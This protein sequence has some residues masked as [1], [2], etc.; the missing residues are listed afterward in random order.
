MGKMTPDKLRQTLGDQYTVQAINLKHNDAIEPGKDA[1]APIDGYFVSNA[2]GVGY[3]LNSGAI[4]PAKSKLDFDVSAKPAE[5][6]AAPAPVSP[7]PVA[8]MNGMN[9][10]M[11]HLHPPGYA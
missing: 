5:N 6:L 1:K 9:H 11:Q 8:N 10:G 3:Y 7:A 2:K 4:D